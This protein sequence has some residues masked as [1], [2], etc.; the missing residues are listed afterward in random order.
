M[1]EKRLFHYTVGVRFEQI[2][3]DGAIKPATAGINTW[4]ERPVVW[5]T[6]RSAWEPTANK[7][8]MGP[9]GKVISLDEERTASVGKGL[10]RISVDENDLALVTWTEFRAESGVPPKVARS[11]QRRACDQGSNPKDWRVT[12][13]P[14]DMEDWTDVEVYNG[15]AGEWMP[16]EEATQRSDP[17]GEPS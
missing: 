1:T 7:L 8:A 16:L 2:L 5:L 9:Q 11:L 12:Y 6:Y 14:I 4:A 3:D 15:K 17:E 10:F 13:D